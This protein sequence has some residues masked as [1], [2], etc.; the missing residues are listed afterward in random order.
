MYKIYI[1]NL[2]DSV[3]L[4]CPY[5]YLRSFAFIK[6]TKTAQAPNFKSE[7]NRNH[8]CNA[9]NHAGPFPGFLFALGSSWL[10]HLYWQWGDVSCGLMSNRWVSHSPRLRF[11]LF[12]VWHVCL[13]KLLI[14]CKSQLSQLYKGTA[15]RLQQFQCED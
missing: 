15:G 6:K 9:T 8:Q 7:N 3:I 2:G 11:Q 10:T 12:H 5:S 13:G 14:L 1:C 4:F